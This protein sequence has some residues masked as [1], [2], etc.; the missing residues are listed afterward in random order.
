M[1]CEPTK[2]N[3]FNGEECKRKVLFLG[4]KCMTRT[5]SS[6]CDESDGKRMFL[7]FAFM[8]CSNFS[9][10]EC[11][12]CQS[13]KSYDFFLFNSVL[14]LFHQTSHS[15]SSPTFPSSF[16]Y[17]LQHSFLVYMHYVF[18]CNFNFLAF[19]S[20]PLCLRFLEKTPCC[21]SIES[22][23]KQFFVKNGASSN[24]PTHYHILKF[25]THTHKHTKKK[26]VSI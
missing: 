1:S 17:R 14:E 10:C 13:E 12:N 9:F 16:L 18:D 24:H 8:I 15:L 4:K 25:Q 19:H 11:V 22:H 7:S 21:L 6:G 3:E 23:L 5:H 26:I 20:E 2:K